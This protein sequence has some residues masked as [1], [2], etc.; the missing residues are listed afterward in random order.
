MK[1]RAQSLFFSLIC[2]LIACTV[3]IN[4]VGESLDDCSENAYNHN[5][6]TYCD[7]SSWEGTPYDP[8][9]HGYVCLSYASLKQKC[10][11]IKSYRYHLIQK[12][13]AYK[14]SDNIKHYVKSELKKVMSTNVAMSDKLYISCMIFVTAKDSTLPQSTCNDIAKAKKTYT[15]RLNS[16]DFDLDVLQKHSELA[17]GYISCVEK[18]NRSCL[19]ELEYSGIEITDTGSD[20]CLKRG[21]EACV[22][23]PD[24]QSIE[25]GNV[26]NPDCKK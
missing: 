8:I 2:G 15:D 24:L 7:P 21:G 3:S 9:G 22:F 13:L 17:V 18:V 5:Y 4:C 16:I 26:A 1:L 11:H 10:E 25:S 6:K 12:A 14:D 23:P 19:L 20:I